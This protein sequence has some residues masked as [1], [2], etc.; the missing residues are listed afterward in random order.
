[1]MRLPPSSSWG[2]RLLTTSSSSLSPHW[3]VVNRKNRHGFRTTI[4][5]T[6]QWFS[7]S[8]SIIDSAASS[9]LS[10]LPS[11]KFLGLG[12][13]K[14]HRIPFPEY[15]RV[16]Q[17]ALE[18][19]MPV[20][21]STSVANYSSSS[22][23]VEDG[24]DAL[25][26]KAFQRAL[27]TSS[28]DLTSKPIIVTMRL[29][30]RTV[31]IQSNNDNN[32]SN[33]N[34][35]PSTIGSSTDDKEATT[36]RLLLWPGDMLLE[37][38]PVGRNDPQPQDSTSSSS[39]M[40]QRVL[41]NLTPDYLQ[42][43][44]LS[45]PLFQLAKQYP[46][47]TLLPMIHNPEAQRQLVVQQQQSSTT[48]DDLEFHSKLTNAFV[49]MEQVTRQH[50][51][52]I[53]GFGVVSHGLTLPS[54]HPMHLD[55]KKVLLP[56]AKAAA[57]E[58]S[59]RTSGGSANDERNNDRS[60]LSVI[61]LAANVLE[62]RGFQVAQAMQ[63]HAPD[64]ISLQRPLHIWAMRPLTSYPDATSS[65]GG[66]EGMMYPRKL[67]DVPLPTT[68]A[69]DTLTP[70]QAMVHEPSNAAASTAEKAAS[71]SNIQMTHTMSP[72]SPPL[73]Y[74]QALANA[75]AHFDATE[76]LEKKQSGQDLT[77]AERE[78]WDGCKLL[79]SMLHDLDNL[80]TNTIQ[81]DSLQ[82]SQN[83]QQ[84]CFTSWEEY[85]DYLY[86]QVIPVL[87]DTFEEYDDESGTVLQE[88]FAAYGIAMRHA[89]C[90]QTRNI[91][92]KQ[93]AT[94]ENVLKLEPNMPMQEFALRYMLE[95]DSGISGI[96]VGCS[97]PKHVVKN[98]QIW[99][100]WK[101]QHNMTVV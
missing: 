14:A 58:V 98:T 79:Q 5:P 83:S 32:Q 10:Q 51:N 67:V 56:T 80:L 22:S 9:L 74:Q 69:T 44:L 17:T 89:L 71:T 41:H 8:S 23:S 6:T 3:Q 60:Y 73:I 90:H 96:I 76:I 81:V 45:S 16:V 27:E 59:S 39:M 19:G 53:I 35:F 50:P 82:V 40:M 62:P 100:Q 2:S 94:D 65:S 70:M 87:H 37:E 43:T 7:S 92:V 75:M 55:W 1:M 31:T 64:M 46:N 15:C 18:Q 28:Y 34:A 24:G 63:E 20:L 42:H 38:H 33:D 49:A 57:M 29:G 86:Q 97:Q 84:R 77:T 12:G 47:V 66:G 54:A 95:S 72:S 25:L 91:I 99:N 52:H 78:T 101:E 30:Y 4:T 13:N 88:F 21:E 36:T 26:A 61:Q 48:Q 85:Q 11:H 68:S 93:M